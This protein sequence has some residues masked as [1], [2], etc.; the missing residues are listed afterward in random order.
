MSKKLSELVSVHRNFLR[1]IR[2]DT[3]LGRAD[4]ISGYILQSPAKQLLDITG[5]YLLESQQKAFT[6]TGP[7]G[8]GKSSLALTLAS[9]VNE[10]KDIR[11][12]SRSI[13]GDEI[14]VGIKQYFYTDEPW[15]VLPIVGKKT[16]IESQIQATLNSIDEQY[17][18]LINQEDSVI[19]QLVKLAEVLPKKSGV[20]LLIDELGK[21]L[22]YA[23]YSGEDIG[24]YQD[25][26]EAAARCKG[27]LVII[28]ILHQSF[29]QYAAKLG[30]NVQQEWAKVQGRYI[31]IPLVTNTD[32]TLELIGKAIHVET[33]YEEARKVA[34]NVSKVI[35]K[36]RPSAVS[37][38]SVLLEACWPLH[39]VMAVMLGPA[40]RKKFGQNE[41]SIFSFL[42]SVEPLGFSEVLQGMDGEIFDY[43]W[44]H[45]F[46]D[47]LRGNFEQ[48]ILAS[49]DGHRWSI[50][51]DA[52]ERAEAIFSNVHVN[53]V[54]TIA[55]I[56][57]FRNGSG[58]VAEDQLLNCS[59]PNASIT[60]IHDALNDLARASILIFRKHIGAWGV[61]AGSDFDIEAALN[62]ATSNVL[63]VDYKELKNTLAFTPI[64]ARRHYWNTGAMRWLNCSIIS[65]R[66]VKKHIDS[67]QTQGSAFGE[68]LLVIPDI[69]VKDK[70]EIGKNEQLVSKAFAKGVLIGFPK[71][72]DNIQ[73]LAKEL[74]SLEFIRN[75]SLKL[76]SDSIAMRE[77]LARIQLVKQTLNDELKYAFNNCLWQWGKQMFT[78]SLSKI[79][80]DLADQIFNL[81]PKV[82]SE[83]VNRNTLSASA[84]KAQKDLLR[85]LLANDNIE[86]LGF[87]NMSA[88]ASLYRTTIKA[89]N[90]HR[91][92]NDTWQI[93]A[94]E[95]EFDPCNIVGVWNG[96]KDFIRKAKG[97]VNLS[98]IFDLLS[99]A[100]FGVKKGLQPI[101]V[102]AF[103]ISYKQYIA[104]YT[105]GM[106]TPDLNETSIDEWLQSPKRI[107]WRFVELKTSE[108][109]MLKLLAN[110][111]SS[112]LSYPVKVEP[113]DSAR[114][115][116]SIV[117][118]LPAWTRKTNSLSK[119]A[120]V[121]RDMLLHASDPH[122]VLFTDLPAVFE[123]TNAELI[124]ERTSEVINELISIF[125]I[126][127]RKIEKNLLT[128]LDQQNINLDLL[129][130]RAK[131]ISGIGAEFRLEAFITR[132]ASYSG[133]THELEGL[134][135]LALGKPSDTWTDHDIDAGELQLIAWATEFRRLEVFASIREREPTRQAIGIVLGG[136]QTITGSFDVSE[137]DANDIEGLSKQL[138]KA[139]ENGQYKKE[140]FLAALVDAGSK[141]IQ[142]LQHIN[143][144]EA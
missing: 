116:V 1:S 102:W 135:M 142:E 107:S 119:E 8:G 36:R 19:N 44:P 25:L 74:A 100:P 77:V 67:F 110:S 71:N 14:N 84:V 72:G 128:A 59:V 111:L 130:L 33:Q 134:L 120:K 56:E 75:N 12:L 113:L 88:A 32:E 63:D 31:D 52:I 82:S 20:L 49:V 30:S 47:Y 104:V 35:H 61:Y 131:N 101:L 46:W 13:L 18:S 15:I 132:M 115:L 136:K 60:E 90:I 38:L 94:P 40:S 139:L 37:N 23:A 89:F 79:A 17:K 83:L 80:S 93:C 95:A 86:N 43:Y 143:G 3:D 103:F 50:S 45:Q 27:N 76:H 48:A 123:S 92:Q 141:V 55:L 64:T 7:Y 70:D 39:P 137:H 81:S 78:G 62:T 65:E 109:K 53:L 68:F 122:K 85:A 144:G 24:F 114:A 73:G 133:Y 105:D 98:E 112:Q 22:E 87:E 28:G 51:V 5:S 4:A 21:F 117:F 66:E 126:R 11:D 10:K 6:W 34:E 41:R 97:V 26:A 124:V 69:I 9:C 138:I 129:H 106:F 125:E 54:K 108:K 58:L 118:G 140:V 127:L 2:L 42:T 57:I 96:I 29:E 121:I 99:K 91:Y 16:S